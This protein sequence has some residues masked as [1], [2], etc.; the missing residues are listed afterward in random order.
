MNNEQKIKE[1]EIRYIKTAIEMLSLKKQDAIKFQRIV[2]EF[3]DN[4]VSLCRESFDADS[5][6]IIVDLIRVQLNRKE[7]NW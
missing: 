6:D 5:T 1:K 4:I 3:T 2:D 7:G